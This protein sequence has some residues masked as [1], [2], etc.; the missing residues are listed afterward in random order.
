[1][2]FDHALYELE[3]QAKNERLD[4]RTGQTLGSFTSDVPPAFG[5]GMEFDVVAHVLHA[6]SPATGATA[7]RFTP[8]SGVFGSALVVGSTVYVGS[9]IGTV[10]ALDASTGAVEW[11]ENTGGSFYGPTIV[12]MGAAHGILVVP[13]SNDLVAYASAGPSFDAGI[14]EYRGTDATCPWTLVDGPPTPPAPHGSA[15]MAVADLN[16]DG[17]LDLLTAGSYSDG[18]VIVLLGAGDGTFR[19][20]PEAASLAGATFAI[21]V[22]DVDGDGKLDVVTAGRYEIELRPTP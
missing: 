17:K 4:T 13:A 14:R 20:L 11:S 21:A 12:G 5:A 1:V 18:G 2:L 3:P 15:S 7:W 8:D 10:F 16:A 22:A 9:S 6:V 19:A